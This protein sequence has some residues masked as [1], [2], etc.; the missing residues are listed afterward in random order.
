MRDECNWTPM[1]FIL[2]MSIVVVRPDGPFSHLSFRPDDRFRQSIRLGIRSGATR[3][4]GSRNTE[5][6]RIRAVSPGLSRLLTPLAAFKFQLCARA[7]CREYRRLPMH[8]A[9]RAPA[10]LPDV[11]TAR[12]RAGSRLSV[13]VLYSGRFYGALT[14]PAWSNDH[15]D[16]LIVPNRAAVFVVVDP[17]NVCDKSSA[18]Q[19]AVR[20]SNGTLGSKWCGAAC[21]SKWATASL[22]L[23]QEAKAVFGGWPHLYAK[24]VP[25]VVVGDV[26][27]KFSQERA[28][29]ASPS[30]CL[31]S[32]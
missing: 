1:A 14:L 30:H 13:A 22:A 12:K 31:Y 9:G 32:H 3:V 19:L 15:L 4:H 26:A 29:R 6:H 24:L 11:A 5:V 8:P 10:A 21:R 27:N 25:R 28:A 20:Q 16:N 18:V 23:L 17:L 2:S 7:R